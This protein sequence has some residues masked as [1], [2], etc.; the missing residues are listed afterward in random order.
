VHLGH[1]TAVRKV[2]SQ[3]IDLHFHIVQVLLRHRHVRRDDD[4]AAAEQAPVLAEGK[5]GVEA[6]GGLGSYSIGQGQPLLIG[7]PVH[8]LVKFHGGRIGSISGA[9]PVEATDRVHVHPKA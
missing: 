1:F 3:S 6:D 9:G 7:S 4:V 8:T 2:G 5:M